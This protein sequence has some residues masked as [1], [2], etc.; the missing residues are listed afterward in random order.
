MN[1]KLKDYKTLKKELRALEIQQKIEKAKLS[2]CLKFQK[3]LVPGKQRNVSKNKIL[4]NLYLSAIAAQ[5]EARYYYGKLADL[6][7][8]KKDE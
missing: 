3:L 6:K 4:I 5:K 2:Y 8:E 7:Q 1:N